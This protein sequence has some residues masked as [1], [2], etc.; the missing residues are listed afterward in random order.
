[1]TVLVIES[2]AAVGHA[3][4]ISLK[5][6]GHIVLVRKSALACSSD[7]RAFEPQVV[8]IDPE[9]RGAV[10]TL[11]AIRLHFTHLYV[12][13]YTN[14]PAAQIRSQGLAD[15]VLKRGRPTNVFA[16]QFRCWARYV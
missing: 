9:A 13:A 7:I 15:L 6:D 12:I 4:G 11:A 5:R 1:M 8:V 16:S 14:E 3:L 10:R 2:D